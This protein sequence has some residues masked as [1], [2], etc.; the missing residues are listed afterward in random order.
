VGRVEAHLEFSSL[1]KSCSAAYQQVEAETMMATETD[2]FIPTRQ[3]LLSRL[4]DWNDQGSWRE[5]FDT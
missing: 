5:F 3:S 4:R 1:K 2:E